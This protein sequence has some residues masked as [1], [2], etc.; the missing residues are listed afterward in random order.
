MKHRILGLSCLATAAVLAAQP[1]A[2]EVTAKDVQVMARALGFTDKAPSGD[3]S[4]GIVYAPGNAQSAK[5]AVDLQKM[6][7]GGL[8][9]GSLTLKPVLVKIDDV[10]AAD[11]GAYLL[12]EGVG[13]EAAKLAAVA[14]AK[15]K[16]CVT[17][18][19][20][21]VQSGACAMGVKSDPKVEIVVNKAAA[22]ASG[23]GFAAAFRM[24]ITEL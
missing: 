10:G 16:I 7:G 4:I 3:L 20:S 5:E 6:M 24:M 9:A 2:A 14:K 11:V 17:T 1:A 12:T 23:V 21:Q 8:S 13:G 22:A 18:D 15:Q 19:M